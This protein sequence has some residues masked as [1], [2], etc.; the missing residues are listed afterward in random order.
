MFNKREQPKGCSLMFVWEIGIYRGVK[1]EHKLSAPSDVGDSPQCGE[2]SAT[3][4]KGA[5]ALAC[6]RS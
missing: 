1:I 3:Q 4:T 5:G 6:Q 2:M